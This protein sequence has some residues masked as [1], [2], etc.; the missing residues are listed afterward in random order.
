MTVRQ[1]EVTA[2]LRAAGVI[3]GL[4]IERLLFVGQ[5]SSAATAVSGVLTE[6]ILNDSAEDTLYGADSPLATAIRRARRRNKETEFLAIG[7][8]DAGGGTDATGAFTITGTATAAGT[9]TFILGSKKFNSFDVPVIIGDTPTTIGDK[10]DVLSAAD[11]EILVTSSNAIGVVTI[12]SKNAG[13][14]GNTIGLKIEGSVTGIAVAVVGMSGGATDPTL[15]GILDVL[16]KKRFQGIVWQW[17]DETDEVKDYL[18]ARFNVNN[19]ILDG[20]AFVGRTNTLANHL[21]TLGTENSESLSINVDKLIS[22]SDYVGPAVL[23]IP[24]TKVAEF[25]AI[26]ALRRTNESVL[27]DLVIARSPLDSFGGPH[28]NSKPYFNTPF[29]DLENPDIGD[30][31]TDVEVEQLLDAGGWVI[32]SNRAFTEVI[33]GEIVTTYKTDNAGNPDP[34]F[35]FLNYVD[36]STASREYIV[37][38]TRSQYPQ[39]RAAGGALTPGIDVAN[40]ASV[41]AFVAEKYQELGDLGLVNIGTGTVNGEAVDYDKEFREN[42][43]VTLNPVTGRFLVAMKLFIVV[44]LRAVVYDMA[45][46]FEV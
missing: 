24:F 11:A 27:G 19:D 41:A 2:A 20:V 34:T 4:T 39:Y 7:V 28:Q 32:D 18:D 33:A 43:T 38:N 31:F 40:E 45:V 12:T 6:N 25:A 44:Q 14:F 26:R 37:N 15:T 5:Q 36:T 8:D 17:Q 9:L 46:A 13:T 29:A 21:T 3:A 1:P 10:L 16:G 30:S 23:E 35:G 22:D 42:L